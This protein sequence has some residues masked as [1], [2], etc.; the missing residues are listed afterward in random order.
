M[1]DGIQCWIFPGTGFVASKRLLSFM[2][3]S[4]PNPDSL[5]LQE[6]GGG[7]GSGGGGLEWDGRLP[8]GGGAVGLWFQVSF[9]ANFLLTHASAT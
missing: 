9:E 7:W 2:F 6:A 1:Q 8:W 4:W 3:W 5:V